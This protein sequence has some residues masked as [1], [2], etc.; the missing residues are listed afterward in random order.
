MFLDHGHPCFRNID[1]IIPVDAI[2]VKSYVNSFLDP[3]GVP[4]RTSITNILPHS[5]ADSVRSRSLLGLVRPKGH[6]GLEDTANA[7]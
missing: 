4:V 1:S 2:R 7:L 6:V 5:K 3:K